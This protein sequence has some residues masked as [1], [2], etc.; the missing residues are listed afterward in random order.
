MSKLDQYKFKQ[1]IDLIVSEDH[2]NA[3]PFDG[4][5]TDLLESRD[6]FT[7]ECCPQCN[8]LFNFWNE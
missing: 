7:I 8:K 6:E 3:C 2:H 1:P 4:A 5:R